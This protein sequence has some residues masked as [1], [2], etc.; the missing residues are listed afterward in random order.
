MSKQIIYIT[1]FIGR[2]DLENYIK[3]EFGVS[4][5][6]NREAEVEIRGTKKQLKN[7]QLSDM[8][9]IWGIKCKITDKTLQKSLIEKLLKKGKIWK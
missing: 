1:N 3:S 9:E 8:T 6:K 5:P 2:V 7:F 4:I